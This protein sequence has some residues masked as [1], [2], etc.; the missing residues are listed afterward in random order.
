M[1]KFFAVLLIALV[2]VSA[3]AS[4]EFDKTACELGAY[5]GYST[6]IFGAYEYDDSWT[7]G[8]FIETEAPFTSGSNFKDMHMGVNTYYTLYD[9]GSAKI[10]AGPVVSF[11]SKELKT[12]ALNVYAG[13]K[14]EYALSE[15]GS[16]FVGYDIPVVGLAFKGGDNQIESIKTYIEDLKKDTLKGFLYY[17]SVG[18]IYK[19]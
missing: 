19:F 1:K 5:A 13:L 11:N 10:S 18:F 12:W 8:V 2:A 4:F 6:G 9:N 17:G 7:V 15:T 3:F 14:A 16:I